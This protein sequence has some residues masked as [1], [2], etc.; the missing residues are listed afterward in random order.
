[1]C[2]GWATGADAEDG[3]QGVLGSS[4]GRHGC[5]TEWL[6]DGGARDDGDWGRR[7]SEVVHARACLLAAWH[8]SG[9]GLTGVPGR[10]GC[11]AS[12]SAC[13]AKAAMHQRVGHGQARRRAG[14]RR[15]CTSASACWWR[16]LVSGGCIV[17]EMVQIGTRKKKQDTQVTS[18][19]HLT[20]Q[21]YSSTLFSHQPNKKQ[22]HFTPQPNTSIRNC[23]IPKN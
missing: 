18:G 2:G 16:Q 23:S 4:V 14:R 15:P 13:Q 20:G 9:D 21:T 1:M 17:R 8:A 11:G 6:R 3:A 10:G 12:T 7:R 22:N 5:G 19:T